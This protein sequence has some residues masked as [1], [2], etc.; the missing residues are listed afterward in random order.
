RRSS[1]EPNY[2]QTTKNR[3][4]LSAKIFT[5]K[6]HP[7]VLAGYFLSTPPSISC[8]SQQCREQYSTKA[9]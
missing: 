7:I 4:H 8:Q 9:V 2:T 5:T 1:E 3:Q 6:Y